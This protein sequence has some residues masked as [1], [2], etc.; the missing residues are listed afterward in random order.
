MLATSNNY[1]GL[2]RAK[3][4][5]GSGAGEASFERKARE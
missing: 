5:R 3:A 4:V 1:P 2:S